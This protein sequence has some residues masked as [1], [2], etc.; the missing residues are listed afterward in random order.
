MKKIVVFGIGDFSDIIVDMIQNKL[1]LSVEGFVI[2]DE[3]YANNIWKGKPVVPLSRIKEN[4]P[5]ENYSIVLG[6]IGDR[7]FD[8]RAV[9][10]RYLKEL[11]Y[12]I[13][14][15]IHPSATISYETIGEGNIF[16][17]NSCVAFGSVIG[18]GN[19]FWP[20]SCVNHHGKIGS[21]NN[22]SPSVSLA[23][24]VTV[25]DHC[26]LGCNSTYN[27]RII[28]HD[29]TFVGAGSYI[30]CNTEPY[31]VYVPPRAIKLSK[32]SIDFK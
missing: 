14:N 21:F 8:L 22:L 19:I 24:G 28:V 7:L 29:Y 31:G 12:K 27:N 1:D 16:L 10:F 4:Y 23:G 32:V 2:D 3:Y 15:I 20:L 26:F 18:D 5:K 9:K 25:G 17:E 11:G 13:E 6:M 30:S